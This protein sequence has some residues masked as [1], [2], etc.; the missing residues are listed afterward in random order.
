ML[1]KDLFPRIGYTEGMISAYREQKEI[2]GDRLEVLARETV[3]K[4]LPFL[5]SCQKARTLIPEMD[6]NTA[7]LMFILECTGYLLK[8]Y[9][10]AGIPE[11]LFYTAMQDIRCKTAECLSVR[12]VFGT[13]V[14]HWYHGFFAMTRFA[15]GRL[16]FDVTHHTGESLT[17]CGHTVAEGDLVLN[18][19]IP[20]LGS[21]PHNACLDSYRSACAFFA[22]E[23]KAG[24]LVVRCNS[25]MLMPDYIPIFQKNAPNIYR[26]AQD[27]VILQQK[28][29]ATFT[30]GWR[31]FGVDVTDRNPAGLPADTRL[32]RGFLEHITT[33]GKFGNGIGYLLFDG[34]Q[35]LTKNRYTA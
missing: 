32:R 18:C 27:F 4:A 16:Q 14:A 5:D 3:A 10:A 15:F 1:A 35:V 22:Q 29:A 12:K 25:W 20:S 30:D 26:F 33:G 19:H 6:S 23:L 2:L 21:L 8:K 17:V 9:Q 28:E 11:A 13:F 31:I 34:R 24:K 7:D